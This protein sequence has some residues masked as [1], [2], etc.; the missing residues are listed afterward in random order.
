MQDITARQVRNAIREHPYRHVNEVELHRGLAQVL[1]G[2]GLEPVREVI[3][4]DKDRIDMLVDLPRVGGRPV[5]LG[6]E[7]KIAGTPGDVRRQLLRYSAHDRVDELL[8]VTSIY[9]H[10]TELAPF[11]G[12]LGGKPFQ[13]ALLQRGLL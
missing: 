7:A 4:S 10:M 3:L 11:R 13:I 5:R 9:R 1:A 2:M 6:I 12:A 8:L